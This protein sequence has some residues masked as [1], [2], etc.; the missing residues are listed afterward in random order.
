M[1]VPALSAIAII[2]WGLVGFDQFW[3]KQAIIPMLFQVTHPAS[4]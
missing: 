2:L 1:W 4:H 3:A